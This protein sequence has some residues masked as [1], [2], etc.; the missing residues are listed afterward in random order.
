M[1]VL[2]LFSI[3]P[4]IFEPVADDVSIHPNVFESIPE[5]NHKNPMPVTMILAIRFVVV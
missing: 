5:S 4:W 1:T 3:A 2:S